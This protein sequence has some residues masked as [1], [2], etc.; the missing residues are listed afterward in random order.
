VGDTEDRKVEMKNLIPQSIHPEST[1]SLGIFTKVG[2]NH[3]DPAFP[4]RQTWILVGG[5]LDPG[6]FHLLL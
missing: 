1:N 3:L 5:W 4:L 6:D 2:E